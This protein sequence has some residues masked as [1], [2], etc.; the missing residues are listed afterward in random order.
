MGR[1]SSVSVVTTG[2]DSS[3]SVVTMDGDSSVSVVT[4]Y[5]LGGSGIKPWWGQD[6]PLVGARFSTPV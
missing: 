1:D 3:A 2:G 5:R 4:S 6:F